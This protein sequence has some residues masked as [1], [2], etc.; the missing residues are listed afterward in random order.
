MYWLHGL[1]HEDAG[2]MGVKMISGDGN[3]LPESK[4]ALPSPLTTFFKVT[5][6]SS[7]FPRSH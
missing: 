3:F 7:L 5:G 4:R 6:L 1:S 2:A